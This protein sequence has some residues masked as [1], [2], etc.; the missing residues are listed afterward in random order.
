MRICIFGVGGIGGYT[1][2]HLAGGPGLDVGVVARGPHLAAIRDRGLRVMTLERDRARSGRAAM[3]G[4]R[5]RA[6]HRLRLLGRRGVTEPGVIRRDGKGAALPIGETDSTRSDRVVA[7]AQAMMEAD[8]RAPVRGNIRGEIWTKMILE[9][10]GRA[11]RGDTRGDCRPARDRRDRQGHDDGGRS[12]RQRTRRR[13]ATADGE[14]H[15]HHAG[16]T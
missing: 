7:L 10:G 12:R 5:A 3:A 1:A 9:S 2:G 6:R 11:D 15:R 4:P 13:P 14:T 8:M 16:C